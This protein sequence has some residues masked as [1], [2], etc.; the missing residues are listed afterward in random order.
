MYAVVYV[1]VVHVYVSYSSK[2]LYSVAFT[3]F[4][5][6]YNNLLHVHLISVCA[7]NACVVN[8]CA[9]NVCVVNVAGP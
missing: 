7:V 1:F 4:Y 2:I 5:S 8:L 9:V 3:H 6:K